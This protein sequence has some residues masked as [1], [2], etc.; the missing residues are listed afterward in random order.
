MRFDQNIPTSFQLHFWKISTFEP[1][2]FL[3]IF[4]GVYEHVQGIWNVLQTLL[5]VSV[6]KNQSHIADTNAAIQSKKLIHFFTTMRRRLV[7][8]TWGSSFTHYEIMS[9]RPVT[10]MGCSIARI[11]LYETRQMLSFSTWAEVWYTCAVICDHG[12]ANT[13]IPGFEQS[14]WK[15]KLN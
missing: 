5:F 15:T 9:C 10:N 6:K 4:C 3:K 2:G 14:A 13:S 7:K 1:K 8:I 12:N 11:F